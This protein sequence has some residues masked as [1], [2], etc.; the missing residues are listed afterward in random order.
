MEI[1]LGR[2]LDALP[3]LAWTARPDGTAE[4]VGRRWLEYTGLSAQEAAGRGWQDALHPD[5]GPR[6]LA[7]W[8]DII[9][10]GQMGEVEARLRRFDGEHRWFL[11]RAAPMPEP[12]GEVTRWCGMNVEIEDRVRAEAALRAEER[13]FEF[14]VEGLPAMV[15]LMTPDGELE[16]GNQ[17]MLDY[18]GRT[19]DELKARPVGF[20]F[21]PEDRS[22]VMA[23]WRRSVAT[24][25]PYDH[26]ARLRRADGVYR[27]FHTRG[28]PLR[29][30]GGRIHVW[31]LLQEDIDQRRRAEAL[32]AGEKR[33]LEQVAR[34][35]QLNAILGDLSDLVESLVPG[36]YCSILLV[37]AGGDRFRVGA[38]PSLA[39]AYNAVLDG[40][41]IDPG[42]GP[43]SLAVIR[44][45]PIITAD[46][47]RDP[48]WEGSD[49]PGLMARYGLASCWSMPI[50]SGAQEVLGIFAIYRHEPE[51]PTADEQE[52]IDRFTKI[53][54]IAIE[55]K[56][57]ED[58][59]NRAS[60]DLAHVARVT[61]LGALTASIAH[62]VNQP[63]AGIITNASTCLRMLAAD[64]PNLDGAR[65]TAQ[66]T[67]R[68]G[69]RASEVIQRLRALF[70]RRAPVMEP[71]DLNAAAREVLAL[72]AG[73]LQRRRVVAHAAFAEDLPPVRGDRVQLQQVILNLVMNAADAMS[74]V[75]DRPREL[76]VSTARAAPDRVA[77]S[78]RD[79]G[80]GI[81]TEGLGRLF[82]AFYT[83]K[84]D[85]MGIGLSI[86]HSI[87]QAHEGRI[88]A[89]PNDG[90][91]M[92]FSFDIPCDPDPAA[93]PHEAGTPRPKTVPK[94]A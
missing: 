17:Y 86:S 89:T 22:E 62:E 73:D 39:P 71:L 8:A 68:D 14:I 9:A 92:T 79:A 83:T 43:C 94:D 40:K 65:A 27:W 78:V 64:P 84:A 52:L 82:D 32:L 70:A 4:H 33:L 21:H 13:R 37:D 28:F 51:G 35:L 50:L 93:A 77:L 61:A 3:G 26:E 48:R 6:L 67:I 87:I 66:R 36:C 24:G 90:P 69:N 31:Y 53:A 72:S 88:W 57:A 12:S 11:F 58:A 38:G 42:Y 30:A 23:R 54:G 15:T 80:V 16:T 75:A 34:G 91:G 55:R 46:L 10:S 1:D 20:S 18:F 49:W 19:L 47:A 5:D 44:K 76:W 60:A 59:L 74:D 25:E 2:L 45:V 81:P 29:D 56:A 41:T 63:L 85:G 7:R